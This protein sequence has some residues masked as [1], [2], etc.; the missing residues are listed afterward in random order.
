M[1]D[2]L[3]LRELLL[4]RASQGGR[5]FGDLAAGTPAAL[6]PGLSYCACSGSGQLGVDLAEPLTDATVVSLPAGALR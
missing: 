5:C 1:G 2:P 6:W 3:E 4:S